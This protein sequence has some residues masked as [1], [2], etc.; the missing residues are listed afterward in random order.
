MKILFVH[1]GTFAANSM[2]H[3][4]PFANELKKQGHEIVITLPELDPTFKVFPYPLVP[5]FAYDDFLE[6][7]FRFEGEGPDIV[8]AWTPREIVRHFCEK[9]WELVEARF[10]IHLEDDEQ[11]IQK[12][13]PAGNAEASSRTS[14]L[15]GPRFLESADAFTVIIDSLLDSIP[16]NKPHHC[17][18][19]GFDKIAADNNRESPFSRSDFAVP[20]DYK[21]ITYPGGAS[22]PNSQDLTDL[23]KAVDLLNQY[24]TPCLLLKTGFPDPLVRN[25]LP[26]GAENWI[27]DLGYLQRDQMWRLIELADVTVQPGRINDYNEK[28]L[29][30]KLPDLFGLGKPVITSSAN[31]GH[32]LEDGK[33]ALLL[34]ES[35][36]EEI[37]ARCQELFSNPELASNIAQEGQ[38]AGESWF[39][40][41]NNII[42]LLLFYEEILKNP[43]TQTR[44]PSGNQ[45]INAI[46]FLE[47]EL[48]EIIPP[49]EEALNAKTY[50]EAVRKEANESGKTESVSTPIPIELQV[51]YPNQSHKLELGSLRR[52]YGRGDPRSCIFPFYPPPQP[53]DWI[54]IDPGQYPGTYVLKSWALLDEKQNALFE[55]TPKKILASYCQL[56]GATAGPITPSGQEI[57]CLTHD[58]QLLFAP[59]PEVDSKRIRWFKVEFSA[60]EVESPRTKKLK[61]R[62]RP[63]SEKKPE[64]E[65][66]SEKIDRLLQILKR[67]RS[68]VLR[69]IDRLQKKIKD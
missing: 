48:A 27:R 28:R 53:L 67:R 58:P 15:H 49:S 2:N 14:P 60:D 10:I 24:G 32:R 12:H 16:T 54:R 40:L 8:H 17:L 20:D 3:I 44:H 47:E 37:A 13:F 6:N 18:L 62:S 4:G 68:P 41:T 42:G 51:F 65:I 50:L 22:G 52:W 39:D 56:N 43:T 19:P 9:L 34:K 25:A 46:E 1:H 59:L 33:Q 11:A 57:W 21:L 66:Q 55:W 38:K 69:I 36:A 23:F 35:T 64:A 31:L 30:S 26:E 5:A 45:I 63:V 7:P 29:P 61:L